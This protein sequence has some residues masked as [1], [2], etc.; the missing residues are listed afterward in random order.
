MNATIYVEGG[1]DGK[2]LRSVCRR[3]F[4]KFFA[5]AGMADRLPKV[6]ACG[7][8]ESVYGDFCDAVEGNDD[9]GRT[10]FL[11]VDSEAPVTNSEPWRHLKGSDNWNRPQNAAADSAH[12]MVQCMEA[13]FYADKDALE[14]FFGPGFNASALSDRVDIE[15]IP[16][17]DVLDGLAAATRQAKRG[18]GRYHKGRHSFDILRLIDPHK[19]TAASSHARKLVDALDK[20]LSG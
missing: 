14:R 18:R 9:Q 1:G 2:L 17:Q 4:S 8:R 6:V 5:K 11:L 13:W 20:A 10:I 7:R 3:A 19:V 16:K 15:D 12:L